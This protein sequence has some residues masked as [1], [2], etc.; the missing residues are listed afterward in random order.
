[1]DSGGTTGICAPNSP[2]I[3]LDDGCFH[4]GPVTDEEGKANQHDPPGIVRCR[5]LLVVVG[6]S[7]TCRPAAFVAAGVV[8]FVIEREQLRREVPGGSD[9]P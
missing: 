4:F 5:L 1:M 9:Y 3:T 8:P 2:R 6:M 7:M